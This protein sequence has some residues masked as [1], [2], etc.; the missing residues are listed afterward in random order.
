MP[1]HSEHG[2]PEFILVSTI[3]RGANFR[4]EKIAGRVIS[5]LKKQ[6]RGW[7]KTTDSLMPRQGRMNR[8]ELSAPPI[9]RGRAGDH[10]FTFSPK[11]FLNFS[12]F[13]LITKRQYGCMPLSLK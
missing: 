3:Q 2:F 8:A 9:A 6:G 1:S 5:E 4:N 12:T 13:G 7:R 10:G 11:S